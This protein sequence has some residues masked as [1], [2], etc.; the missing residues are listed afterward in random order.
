LFQK[1]TPLLMRASVMKI[2]R[3]SLHG[4]TF[5]AGREMASR[6]ACLRSTWSNS[7]VS[8]SAAKP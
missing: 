4:L 3:Y 1:S 7:P 2:G 8:C 5:S 6:I